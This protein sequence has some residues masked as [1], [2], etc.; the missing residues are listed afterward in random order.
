MQNEASISG[1]SLTG[2]GTVIYDNWRRELQS[3]KPPE[4]AEK[5][6]EKRKTRIA[7]LKRSKE[8]EIEAV[9]EIAP[10]IL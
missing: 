3:E 9:K 6:A 2:Y 10:A 1:E 4:T 5:A 8:L 7:V